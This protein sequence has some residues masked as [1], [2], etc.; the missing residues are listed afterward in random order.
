MLKIGSHVGMKGK[1]M[2]LGSAKE[3]CSYGANTFMVFTGAPQNTKRKP[4]AELNIDAAWEFMDAHGITEPVIHA[5]YII[6][7]GNSFHADTYKL[8]VEFLAMDIERAAAMGSHILVLHP[9][10]HVGAGADAGIRQIAQGLNEILSADSPCSI[11]LETMAGK[12]SEIGR[13]FEELA[14]IFDQVIHNDKLRICLDTCHMHDSGYDIIHD[15]DG[16]IERLDK[17]IGKDKVSVIHI[18]DSKNPCGA[19]KDRHANIGKGYIGPEA[20]FAIV[21]HPDFADIPKILETP[22]CPSEANPSK[23]VP[24]YKEEISML[25]AGVFPCQK[26]I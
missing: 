10:S 5:P 25:K 26:S 6:N 8:A 24:P 22:Y 3:A 15:F 2:M 9:G 18:N 19:G 17:L 21:H 7:L 12:G 16:V 14:A 4:I 1:E 20:L 11:A 13:N 23:T